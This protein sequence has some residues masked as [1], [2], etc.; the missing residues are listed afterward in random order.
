MVQMQVATPRTL[1]ANPPK[2][3][4]K[5]PQIQKQ[6]IQNPLISNQEQAVRQQQSQEMVQIMLHVSVSIP[7][8]YTADRSDLTHLRCSLE[9]YSISGSSDSVDADER[10]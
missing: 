8:P 3:A 10:I 2:S 5:E 1:G 4:Q 7:G 6:V 9:H